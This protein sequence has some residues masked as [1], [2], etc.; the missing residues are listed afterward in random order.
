MPGR[1]GEE[2]G[3]RDGPLSVPRDVSLAHDLKNV[4]HRLGLLLESFEGRDETG[5]P[6]PGAVE[7]LGDA[8]ERLR[9]IAGE[10]V[11]GASR[12]DEAVAPDRLLRDALRQ[13]GDE[14]R[15]NVRIEERYGDTPALRG[16]A[17]LLRGAFAR[18]IENALQAMNGAGKLLLRTRVVE[19]GAI[20]V[21]IV[22]S[23]P[24][25]R[26]GF[27]RDELFRPPATGRRGGGGLG[28]WT[29]RRVAELHG[30]S[31]R[32]LTAPEQGTRVRFRFPLG[33]VA[34]PP[35]APERGGSQGQAAGAA[36]ISASR[37]PSWPS[38]NDS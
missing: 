33:P 21:E 8:V 7:A 13:C 4:A 11:A 12:S 25:M 35:A 30:G 34:P 2:T 16:D 23:G 36:P 28:A 27:L 19:G 20:L 9:R 29:Y 15:G 5:S 18:A 1:E 24:G 38:P 10:L 14:L 17:T 37:S 31:V 6:A 32:V 22:D 3:E 26:E